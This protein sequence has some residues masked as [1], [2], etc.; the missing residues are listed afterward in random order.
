MLADFRAR[1]ADAMHRLDAG[2][3]TLRRHGY[4]EPTVRAVEASESP[5]MALTD[6][7]SAAIRVEE[8]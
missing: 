7:G 6:G 5:A 2:G 3:M 8:R 4:G 1:Q